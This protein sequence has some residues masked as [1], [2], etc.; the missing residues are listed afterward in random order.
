[1][2]EIFSGKPTGKNYRDADNETI[3]AVV[4]AVQKEK[5]PEGINNKDVENLYHGI[6]QGKVSVELTSWE[7]ID[8]GDKC[9]QTYVDRRGEAHLAPYTI[10]KPLPKSNEAEEPR[11]AQINGYTPTVA[12]CLRHPDGE[13]FAIYVAPVDMYPQTEPLQKMPFGG[14]GVPKEEFEKAKK[15]EIDDSP[16]L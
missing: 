14:L 5:F 16:S 9:R 13:K 1:V 7:R 10:E 6:S 8:L 3:R 4:A 12:A 11:I 2:E 15:V